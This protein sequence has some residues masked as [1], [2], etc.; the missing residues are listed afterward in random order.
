M[1]ANWPFSNKKEEKPKVLSEKEIQERLYGVYRPSD[2]VGDPKPKTEESVSSEETSSP[3]IPHAEGEPQSHTTV[4]NPSE[5]HETEVKEE[6][7][8][9][10]E[11]DEIQEKT[12]EKPE[13]DI[14]TEYQS[15]D[16]T[17]QNE[18]VEIQLESEAAPAQGE[19]PETNLAA[20]AE[21]DES[22]EAGEQEVRE[23][24]HET[25][26]ELELKFESEAKPQDQPEKLR[27]EIGSTTGGI[28]LSQGLTN[29]QK[30]K[31]LRAAWFTIREYIEWGIDTLKKNPR[32]YYGIIGGVLALILVVTLGI[33]FF[34]SRSA[35]EIKNK[36]VVSILVP[37][38]ADA[39]EKDTSISK[40]ISAQSSGITENEIKDSGGAMPPPAPIAPA[41]LPKSYSVQLCLSDDIKASEKV[42]DDLRAK[43]YEGYI[44]KIR[45]S[46]GNQLYQIF[47]GHYKTSSDAQKALKELRAD[48][49][50][51]I[52]DDSFVRTAK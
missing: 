26:Q 9:S 17:P 4:L 37:E 3:V 25:P 33:T 23:T 49:Q 30:E 36:N 42:I 41:N 35:D 22:S 40:P 50:F 1:Q 28:E 27:S 18:E 8:F 20:E 2:M 45:G 12:A 16:N 34:G 14:H 43:G 46:R 11:T 21:K 44:R 6:L 7:N 48:S 47:I 13:S 51:K 19:T 31:G 39:E 5:S 32:F 38:T 10:N 29:L 24:S 52:Y 15:D